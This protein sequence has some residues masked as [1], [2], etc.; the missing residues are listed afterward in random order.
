[1]EPLSG[2]MVTSE[3]SCAVASAL[4]VALVLLGGAA[5][6]VGADRSA[7]EMPA[8]TATPSSAPTAASTPYINLPTSLVRGQRKRLAPRRGASPLI[9]GV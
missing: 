7:S 9:P 3:T 2:T 1:V 5:W 6:L 8:A 4:V